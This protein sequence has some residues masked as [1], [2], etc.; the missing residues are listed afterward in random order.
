MNLGTASPILHQRDTYYPIR[1]H[2]TYYDKSEICEN[3]AKPEGE[4]IKNTQSVGI[5]NPLSGDWNNDN[6]II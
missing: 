2:C 3:F 4:S 5:N 1:L 6:V